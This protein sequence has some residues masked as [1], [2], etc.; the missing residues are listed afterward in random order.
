MAEGFRSWAEDYAHRSRDW[1]YDP[2]KVG[3]AMRLRAALSTAGQAQRK[4]GFGFAAR[5]ELERQAED[6]RRRTDPLE[7]AKTYLTKLLRVPIYAAEV[8]NGPKGQ[9][10]V[11]SKLYT[12]EQ[13]LDF[14]RAKGWREDGD[15][16]P[17]PLPKLQSAPV[18]PAPELA[19]PAGETIRSGQDDARGEVSRTPP[20]LEASPE[21][22]PAP[23]E[24]PFPNITPPQSEQEEKTVVSYASGAKPITV[25]APAD[26][27]AAV[28]QL[29]DEQDLPL[30]KAALIFI[31][32]ALAEPA[33]PHAHADGSRECRP[34]DPIEPAP[35]PL[36]SIAL[37]ALLAEIKRRADKAADVEALGEAIA[38]A[39]AA[40]A[41]LARLREA[42]AA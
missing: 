7:R 26:V 10:V 13:L 22:D 1:V 11:G 35:L 3:A 39:E 41:R 24:V 16:A 40:E 33:D 8:A 27:Y 6:E 4:S 9:I 36:G 37:D 32:R 38:R 2:A 14:A 42:L 28:Q 17:P 25:P 18:I 30:G 31:E 34:V 20:V 15:S 12:A 21:P 19:S 23:T 5:A 29:A